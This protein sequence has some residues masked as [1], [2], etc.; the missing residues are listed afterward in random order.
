MLVFVRT[1]PM[2]FGRLEDE[3][4]KLKRFCMY[5]GFKMLSVLKT[6]NANVRQ[7]FISLDGL[8]AFVR[9]LS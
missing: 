2:L 3:E 1:N 8:F 6:S 5:F 7:H 4:R 9:R